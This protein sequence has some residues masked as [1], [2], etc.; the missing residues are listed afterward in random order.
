MCWY[1]IV[2]AV[3]ALRRKVRSGAVQHVMPL[4]ARR[5]AGVEALG[6]SWAGTRRGNDE[7]VSFEESA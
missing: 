7:L 3:K 2:D 1:V 4:C 5:D 6:I